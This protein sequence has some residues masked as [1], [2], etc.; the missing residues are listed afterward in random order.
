MGATWDGQGVNFA[1]F[2]RNATAVEL[3]LFDSETMQATAHFKLPEHTNHVWHGYLPGLNPGQLYGYRVHGPYE[4]L[5]GHFF[6]PA[7][8]LID[9]YAR[10]IAGGVDWDEG[11]RLFTYVIGD[12]EAELSYDERDSAPNVPKCVVVDP[13]FDWEDDRPPQIPLHH[14]VIYEVH[15]KGFTARHPEVPPDLRGTFLALTCQPV[16]DYLK[17]LGVTAVELLPVHQALNDRHLSEKGLGNYWGYNTIGFFAPDARFC[18]S[19]VRGQ[20]VTEFKQMV[21]ALHKAGFE[22]ILDVV[23]NHTGEGSQ[24]GP[25]LSF[26]GIDNTSYYRLVPD[27]PRFYFDVTGTGNTLNVS[28]PNVLQLIADSLRYW[29]I[30]MH[31]DG[32]RFD[33]AATLGRDNGHF[34]PHS[35]FLDILNQDPVLSKVKLIAEPWDIGDN[36]YQLGNFPAGW[37]EWNGKYR[38]TMRDFWRGAEG[39]L[40]DFAT[41][42]TA[43]HDLYAHAGRLPTASINFLTAHD[44]F[45]LNDL[46]SYN[47]KHNTA[48]GED[49]RD[50][51]SNNRSWNLGAEG[52]TEDVAINQL[53]AKQKRNFL[54]T[55]FLSEGVPM[56]LGGDEFGRTQGG[57]NNAYCQDNEISWFDWEHMDQD[58]LAFTRNLIRIRQEHP[59]FHRHRWFAGKIV[60][61]TGLRDIEWFTPGGEE[62][63]ETHWQEGFAKSLAVFYNGRGLN[64]YDAQGHRVTDDSF[65]L[66]INAYSEPLM[67]NLPK[68]EWLAK[69]EKVLDTASN[70]EGAQTTFAAQDQVTLE[71]R[72]L[73]LLRHVP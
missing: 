15:T 30:D 11:N 43:S 53:R 71:G 69:W 61:G 9:P 21:K 22:V 25:T 18:S 55:L 40:G 39:T 48:N 24:L 44:G 34:D 5:Q 1:L 20:Q 52:P 19:G 2:S 49:N 38:D 29:V 28:Q 37:S 14:S 64:D 36:G 42:F 8:L 12:P 72:S 27:S 65:Y 67:Y 31:V 63:K 60:R 26:R 56:L 13:S 73:V 51:E 58:L 17:S 23:Y 10:A 7:K 46:V 6:N 41:R 59:V 70:P 4:P 68:P 45:T 3:C 32:F 57:N 50:G 66:M 33:L 47:E 62:M 16:L 54:A 35:G